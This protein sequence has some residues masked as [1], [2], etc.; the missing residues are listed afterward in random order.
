VVR[1]AQT[2]VF[3][4]EELL[5][6]PAELFARVAEFLDI[7]PFPPNSEKSVHAREYD[8][9]MSADEERYLKGVLEQEIRELVG[10]SAGIA[11]RG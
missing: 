9:T 2:V 1:V 3:K 5:R 11:R 4:S 10:C 6:K 8:V 7:A